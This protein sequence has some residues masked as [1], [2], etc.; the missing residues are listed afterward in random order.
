MSED[1]PLERDLLRAAPALV[2]LTASAWWRSVE[3]TASAS[4]RTGT[5]AIRAAA[6]GE[7]PAKVLEEAGVELRAY[8]WD[9]L[10]LGGSD[11]R[12]P[13]AGSTE[14]RDAPPGADS[15]PDALRERGAELLRRSADVGLEED[16]HPAYARILDELAPDEGRILRMLAREGPQ[17]AVD[18]RTGSLPVNINS[19][20]VAPGLTMIA[21]EAGCRHPDRLHAYLD[22]LNRLGL[23]W[24]SRETLE[25]LQRYQV[26]EAQPEVVNA[27][28]E[29]GRGRTVRRSIHLTPFG[30]DFCEMCLP[31]E[32]GETGG[33]E[34]AERPAGSPPDPG[35]PQPD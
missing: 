19:Q 5:R 17:P 27:M 24:F 13:G 3:W 10:G 7:S 35:R 23:I 20:L 34:P 32:E 9:M 14:E 18:V 28:D 26:L 11:G 2:R 4:V 8:V 29:A 15:T 1:R 12:P 6:S 33:A 16:F 25:D 31:L 22:N 21:A 30:E